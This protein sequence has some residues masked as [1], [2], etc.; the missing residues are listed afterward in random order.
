MRAGDL[1]L[2]DMVWSAELPDEGLVV[3]SHREY[4]RLGRGSC[5]SRRVPMASF[6]EDGTVCWFLVP[7]DAEVDRIGGGTLDPMS[8][9]GRTWR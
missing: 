1:H 6:R 2:G 8:H 9:D 4:R 5:P 7:I 3:R